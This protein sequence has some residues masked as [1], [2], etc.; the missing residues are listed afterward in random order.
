MNDDQRM[1]AAVQAT[2]RLLDILI[3]SGS[4]REEAALAMAR[5]L[6]PELSEDEL[7]TLRPE[8]SE[9]GDLVVHPVGYV[10]RVSMTVEFKAP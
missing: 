4:S 7:K 1:A 8:I 6:Y 9:H 2:R 3:R 5:F 10:D